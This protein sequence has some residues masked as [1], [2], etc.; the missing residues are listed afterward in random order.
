[1]NHRLNRQASVWGSAWLRLLRGC[2]LAFCLTG[3]ALAAPA[4]LGRN[5][6]VQAQAA[7]ADASGTEA[8]NNARLLPQAT[9]RCEAVCTSDSGQTITQNWN[10]QSMLAHPAGP[11]RGKC[12]DHC[13]AR[14]NEMTS[15]WAR[16]G[17]LCKTGR[18]T[19]TSSLGTHGPI[20]LTAVGFDNSSQ[21]FC[22]TTTGGGN[23]CCPEF[24]K[25]MT[26]SHWASLF[27]VG[28]HVVG[29]PYQVSL[30]GSAPAMASLANYLHNWAQWLKLDGCARAVGFR[31]NFAIH[32]TGVNAP[33]APAPS[34]V[35]VQVGATQ[36]IS[37]T[38]GTVT[39]AAL[40]WSMPSSLNWHRVFIRLVAVDKAGQPVECSKSAGCDQGWTFS[41]RPTAA[42]AK[43]APGTGSGTIAE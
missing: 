30:N 37:T 17:K 41:Y 28:A 13:Q 40:N 5:A 2:T 6:A 8:A 25:G 22:K 15:V 9:C 43:L 31:L 18:C 23:A 14:L 21:D 36:A 39:P 20:S 19:G 32:D 34:V 27:T 12:K 3:T 16:E 33:N 1:M 11:Q 38:G 10:A 26:F 24:T 29:Q 7:P 42:N 35:G 4:P